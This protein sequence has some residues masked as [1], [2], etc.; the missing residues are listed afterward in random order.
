MEVRAC[1]VGLADLLMVTGD[2]PLTTTPPVAPGQEVAGVVVAVADGSAF[3]P[4]DRVM[5]ST[6]FLQGWGGFSDYTYI[7]E[8][9]A[10]KIPAPLTDEEAAG[11]VIGFRTAYAGLVQRAAVTPGEVLVVLGAAGNTGAA[12]VQLGKALGARVIAVVGSDEK[13]E[14]CSRL[15]ADHTV[16]YHRTDLVDVVMT[17][18]C[19]RGADVIFDPVGGE[20]AARAVS[21]ISRLGRVAVVGYASGR[22]VVLDPVDMVLRNYSGIGV[23]AGGTPEEDEHAYSRLAKLVTI[24]AI[25]TSVAAVA[26]FGDVPEVIAGIRSAPAGRSVIRLR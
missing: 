9:T 11:S 17:V 10:Q 2:Y 19:G 12:A 5:G 6:A 4:G 3:A 15:G 24:R 13:A 14:F 21:A 1:A 16:N 18:S 20:L 26:A 22:F 8:P 7:R 25:K 23:F